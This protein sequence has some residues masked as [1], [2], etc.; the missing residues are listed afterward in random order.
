MIHLRGCWLDNGSV[1]SRRRAERARIEENQRNISKDLANFVFDTS[2][3]IYLT[4]MSELRWKF[5]KR[6]AR[7]LQSQHFKQ[8][9]EIA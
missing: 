7:L 1:R 3:Y 9:G 6:E 5:S 2:D 4:P 8:T